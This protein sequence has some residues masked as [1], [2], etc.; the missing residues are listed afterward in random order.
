MIVKEVVQEIQVEAE[1]LRESINVVSQVKQLNV[2][3]CSDK[4]P[5][6]PKQESK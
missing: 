6:K 5:K 3:E 1:K 4:V 2:N